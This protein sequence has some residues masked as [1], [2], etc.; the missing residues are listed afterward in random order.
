MGLCDLS[1]PE[2]GKR[3]GPVGDLNNLQSRR[4][5]RNQHAGAVAGNCRLRLADL[6][7]ELILCHFCC[8]EVFKERHTKRIT[9]LLLFVKLFF[10]FALYL[11]F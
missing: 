11:L 8:F 4:P 1:M 2:V 10:S 6:S 7:G 5:R 3:H 9:V